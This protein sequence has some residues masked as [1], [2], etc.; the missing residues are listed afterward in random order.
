MGYLTY[1]LNAEERLVSLVRK[2]WMTLLW[3]F[4]KI[5]LAII[6]L[7]A[8]S[9][10]LFKFGFGVYLA[11]LWIIASFLYLVYEIIVWYMDCF[12]ITDRRIID[13]DQKSLFKRITA[14]TGMDDIRNVLSETSG[15]FQTSFNY[16]TV[17]VICA[18]GGMIAMER[19][20][21]PENIRKLIA[22][23]RNKNIKA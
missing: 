18:D 23:L 7:F 13:I 9:N 22:N 15:F 8:L 2:H 3:P 14:E 1:E 16:G 19:V 10:F 4:A 17:K 6:A 5:V 21:D 11:F 20:P 12:I